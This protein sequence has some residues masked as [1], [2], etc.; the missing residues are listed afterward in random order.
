MT[1]EMLDL[2]VRSEAKVLGSGGKFFLSSHSTWRMR[3]PHLTWSP[4]S[5]R[6]TS[7]LSTIRATYTWCCLRYKPQPS[8]F[9][10]PA[11]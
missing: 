10:S 2:A 8:R 3:D 6:S 9:T 4:G 11:I 7:R 1:G 5:A